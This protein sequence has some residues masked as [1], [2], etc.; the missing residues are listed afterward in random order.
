MI[1]SMGFISKV[2]NFLKEVKTEVKKV[3]WPTRQETLRYTL[4]VVAVSFLV[5]FFLG[6][7]DLLFQFIIEKAIIQ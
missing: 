2:I 1:V 7:L 6:G 4:I 5:A 3:N